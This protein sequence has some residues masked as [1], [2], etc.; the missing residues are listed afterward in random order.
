VNSRRDGAAA[1]IDSPIGVPLVSMIPS[2]SHT[3]TSRI[4][5]EGQLQRG[6]R[7]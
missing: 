5:E 1:S 2:L 7:P 4:T 3:D 6:E